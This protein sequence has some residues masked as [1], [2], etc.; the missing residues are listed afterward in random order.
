MR[1]I[2]L[3]I[4]ALLIAGAAFAQQPK[5]PAQPQPAP[6]QSGPTD[7]D[8]A[9]PYKQ[10]AVSPPPKAADAA[11]A[12]LRQK[13]AD[14]AQRKDRTALGKLVV[15][16]G[17]F[18]DRDGA[19]AADAKKSSIQNL[20]AVI[21]LE[22]KD[23]VGWDMLT[24]YAQD[25]TGSP[26]SDHP[27]TICSPADPT[28]DDQ[29]MQTLLESTNSDIAEWGYPTHD[30]VEVRDKPLSKGP[31]STRLGNYFVRVAPDSSAAAAA[32]SMLRIVTP[33]GKFGYVS[34]DDIAPLGNDQLCYA[35]EAG[36][37]KIAGY[38]GAGSEAG[39]E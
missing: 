5:P 34:I 26:A 27:G 36:E 12:A 16:K 32:G 31:A 21:G 11:L 15:S 13:I 23:P 8:L 19:N 9:K 18:W 10:V 17:F 33:A 7:A 2:P 4:A 24:G 28:F 35:K 3:I 20:S 39:G 29:A 38:I 1:T 22:G 6:A 30:G 37:W 25:Q 14:A